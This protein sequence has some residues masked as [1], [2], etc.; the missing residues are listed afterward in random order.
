[1]SGREPRPWWRDVWTSLKMSVNPMY[2]DSYEMT[3]LRLSWALIV[4][5]F[6]LFRYAREEF[7]PN[8]VFHLAQAAFGLWVFVMAML[9]NP[10]GAEPWWKSPRERVALPK[11][12]LFRDLWRRTRD[13]D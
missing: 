8:S 9:W 1:M 7:V 2:R 13:D 5:G 11:S 12:S 6:A 10:R 3:R 4:A